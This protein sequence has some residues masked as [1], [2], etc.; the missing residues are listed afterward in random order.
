MTQLC[1]LRYGAVPIVARVGGL[2]DTVIDANEMALAAGVATGIVFTPPTRE[3][4]ERALSRAA[5]VFRDPRRWARLQ[6]NGMQTDVSWRGP[7]RQ[8]A[9]LYRDALASVA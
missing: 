6:A 9:S 7:A 2:A 3:R 8:Y 1:A 4:L 5:A